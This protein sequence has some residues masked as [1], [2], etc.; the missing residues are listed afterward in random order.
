M[1][2]KRTIYNERG[3]ININMEILANEK[4]VSSVLNDPD[5]LFPD[6]A[7]EKGGIEESL[8]E[9]IMDVDHSEVHSLFDVDN[10]IEDI[11]GLTYVELIK[12]RK[13]INY[14]IRSLDSARTLYQSLDNI[15]DMIGSFNTTMGNAEKIK[16]MNILKKM[17]VDKQ[18]RDIFSKQLEQ[19][20]AD[21]QR[22]YE[23]I[24]KELEKYHDVTVTSKFISDQCILVLEKK[25]KMIQE[26]PIDGRDIWVKHM[27]LNSYDMQIWLH[28]NRNDIPVLFISNVIAQNKRALK[29][30]KQY[31]KG[32]YKKIFDRVKIGLMNYYSKVS[33]GIFQSEC[34]KIFDNKESVTR[35]FIFIFNVIDNP[36]FNVEYNSNKLICSL[37]ISNMVDIRNGIY[38]LGNIENYKE[39]MK[40]IESYIN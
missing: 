32:M 12:M 28:A 13:D 31:T 37:L 14:Q 35:L 8:K 26:K 1:Q 6:I 3:G 16:T 9:T 30:M 40:E 21:V 25:K 5:I 4:E 2:T 18:S 38:N 11:H 15:N 7:L 36:Q 34:E 24:Q 20:I 39:R 17:G 23:V 22:I 33:L 10:I 27:E 19:N 29:K